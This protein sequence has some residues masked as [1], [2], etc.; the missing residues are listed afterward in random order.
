MLDETVVRILSFSIRLSVTLH[1]STDCVYRYVLQNNV[2][3]FNLLSQLGFNSLK[4]YK[5]VYI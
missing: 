2:F 3:K 5:L 1:K 4:T